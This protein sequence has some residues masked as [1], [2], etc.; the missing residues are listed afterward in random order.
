MEN[1]VRQQMHYWVLIVKEFSIYECTQRLKSIEINMLSDECWNMV[2][3]A[4]I[5]VDGLL[6]NKGGGLYC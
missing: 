6:F 4:G 3:D 1:N 5:C 2:N